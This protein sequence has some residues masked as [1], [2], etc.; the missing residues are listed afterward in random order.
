MS[1]SSV[2]CP[3]CK[4]SLRTNSP[5]P[6]GKSIKCP[7]C[8]VIFVVPGAAATQ[9]LRAASRM[10]APVPRTSPSAPAT[11]RRPA[12]AAAVP[13]Q[14]FRRKK[15]NGLLVVGIVC[16]AGVVL[17]LGGGAVAA[18]FLLSLDYKGSP[19]AAS[20][21]G[22]V[23]TTEVAVVSTAPRPADS[24]RVVTVP[25]FRLPDPVQ[26]PAEPPEQSVDPLAFLPPDS[27]VVVGANLGS[28]ME[29]P[30]VAAFMEP[31][32]KQGHVDLEL[33][34]SVG[35]P[36]K[37]FADRAVMGFKMD[38]DAMNEPGAVP[39]EMTLVIQSRQPFDGKRLQQALG[40]LITFKGKEYMRNRDDANPIKFAFVPSNRLLVMSSLPLEKLHLLR[41]GAGKPALPEATVRVVRQ[42]DKSQVWMAMALNRRMRREMEVSL[43]AA[44]NLGPDYQP[45]LASLKKAEGFAIWGGLQDKKLRLHFGVDCADAAGAKALREGAAKLWETVGKPLAQ[46]QGAQMKM[47]PQYLQDISSDFLNS[48]K[49]DDKETLAQ[50]SIE[51]RFEPLATLV[52]EI[53]EKGPQAFAAALAQGQQ[54]V[55]PPPQPV[56]AGDFA[57]AEKDLLILM[58]EARDRDKVVMFKMDP[59]LVQAARVHSQNMAKQ[60]KLAHELDGK[61]FDKRTS[62]AGYNFQIVNEYVL[63]GNGRVAGKQVYEAMI[64]NDQGRKLMLDKAYTETGI[65]FARNDKNEVYIT[66]VVASPVK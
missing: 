15:G 37:E 43:A 44:E 62:E 24:G 31:L 12:V 8:N 25:T 38:P 28:I 27:N 52:K 2:T 33:F 30:E 7:R 60:M 26:P 45:M 47:L 18:W 21:T 34:K 3:G 19:A 65:A 29:I 66:I 57:E 36:F 42:I 64:N 23:A 61:N 14:D 9:Q 20:P 55:K 17:L 5:L 11:M 22:A 1:P 63:K 16:A 4:A 46:Q 40:G 50:V 59:K 53:E 41:L 10:P 56:P 35:L 51:L 58:N 48:L 6:P 39:E 49:F 13:S 54:P 32:L